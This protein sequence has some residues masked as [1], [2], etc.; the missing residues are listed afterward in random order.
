[1]DKETALYIVNYCSSFLTNEERSAIRHMHSLQKLESPDGVEDLVRKEVYE[2][3][4]WITEDKSVL[5]LL[6]DGYDSFELRTAKRILSEHTNDIFLNYCPNC[7]KL[8]RTPLAKQ[9]RHCGLDWHTK[10]DIIAQSLRDLTTSAIKLADMHTFDKIPT[11]CKYLLSEVRCD[12][13]FPDLHRGRKYYK[14]EKK[15]KPLLSSSDIVNELESLYGDLIEVYVEVFRVKRNLTIIEVRYLL[16][17]S[18]DDIDEYLAMKMI[19]KDQLPIFRAVITS[20]PY[21]F[22]LENEKFDIN[23]RFKAIK[24]RW[25]MLKA[26]Q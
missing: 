25:N 3:A 2:K 15:K 13:R 5:D 7:Q 24:C 6:A 14:Q 16:N 21:V 11:E 19:I 10:A 8:A 12:L 26:R 18:V 1:M 23:W 9:C 4:N 20:P 17:R 22:D